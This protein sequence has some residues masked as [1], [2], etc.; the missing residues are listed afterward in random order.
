M[1]KGKNS[2]KKE[3]SKKPP[4]EQKQIPPKNPP[5]P[6]A[7]S[8]EEKEPKEK[9]VVKQFGE[10]LSRLPYINALNQKLILI[11]KQ[12]ED[13]NAKISSLAGAISAL[14]GEMT[15]MVNMLQDKVA[16][17]PASSSSPDM[18][19]LL[20]GGQKPASAQSPSRGDKA[21]D[22][23]TVLTELAKV[24]G[25]SGQTSPPASGT[26][27]GISMG[28]KLGMET[29]GAMTKVMSDIYKMAANTVKEVGS[30][31]KSLK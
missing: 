28:I 25:G 17:A 16:N 31:S 29:L 20:A 30:V 1:P 19:T 14:N 18:E 24:G 8:A 22:W 11:D 10:V 27:Q 26:E 6:A 13:T 3:V 7:M 2:K 21:L 15:K 5:A 12:S 9:M 23:I 4:K